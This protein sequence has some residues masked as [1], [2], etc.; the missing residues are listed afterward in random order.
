M[1]E[2]TIQKPWID[3]HLRHTKVLQLVS[4][5]RFEFN[6]DF[7]HRGVSFCMHTSSSVFFMLKD[8]FLNVKSQHSRKFWDN[9]M[10]KRDQGKAILDE[11]EFRLSKIL[12]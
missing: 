2:A 12:Y 10:C 7:I 1:E 9:S 4:Y 3:S 11:I 6:I 5:L 8:T